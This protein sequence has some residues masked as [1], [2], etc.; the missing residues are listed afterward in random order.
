MQEIHILYPFEDMVQRAEQYEHEFAE[1][2]R[3][4]IV[5][6][7]YSYKQA[8]GYI[9]LE[10]DDEVDPAFLHQLDTDGD[11]LD[12]SVYSLPCIVVEGFM[13]HDMLHSVQ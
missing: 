10:W 3:V 9:V 5:D 7:G 12:Y 13:V 1:H 6:W 11:V 8:Q 4:T 2:E